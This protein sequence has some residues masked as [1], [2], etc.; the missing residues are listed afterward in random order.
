MGDC[1]KWMLSYS[2]GTIIKVAGVEMSL[3][4]VEKPAF[5]HNGLKRGRWMH[6]ADWAVIA[7]AIIEGEE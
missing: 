7:P 1:A 3:D 5:G 2:N 4:A 6:E